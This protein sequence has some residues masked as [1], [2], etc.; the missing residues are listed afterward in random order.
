M[1]NIVLFYRMRTYFGEQTYR[2]VFQALCY[3]ATYSEH[4]LVGRSHFGVPIF[5][6][7]EVT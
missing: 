1:S 7:G 5:T 2:V 3:G 4:K 6:E